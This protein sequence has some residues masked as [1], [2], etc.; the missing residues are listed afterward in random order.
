LGEHT[1]KPI[2]SRGSIGRLLVLGGALAAVLLF[3]L[4]KAG[5]SVQATS[6]QNPYVAPNVVDTNPKAHVV[7]TTLISKAASVDIGNGV[8]AH[9]QTFNGHIPGPTFHLNVGDTV[10]VHYKNRLNRPSGIHWHGVEVPNESDGTPFVQDLV[11]P[12]HSF[13][14]KFKVNRPGIFWYHPHHHDSTDQVFKGLYGMIVVT[15]PNEAKLDKLR[16]IPSAK[17]TIPMVLSD[18]TVCKTQGSNDTATYSPTAP[19]VGGGSLPPQMP[20]TPKNLCEGPGVT[21]PPPNPYP[22]DEDGSLR[23]PFSA[24]DIP[25][26]QTALHAGRVNEGQTVL[27]NGMNVGARAGTPSA[28]GAL[29][30]GASTLKVHPG[31]G[32]RMQILNASTVRYMRLRLTSPTGTQI[33]LVRIGGEGG[34]LNYAVTEGGLQGAY[35]TKYSPGEILLPPGSRAD[36]VAAIPASPTSGVATMW[37][38]DYQRSGMGYADTPTV[39]VAHFKIA[40]SPAPVPFHITGGSGSASLPPSGTALRARTGH[41]VQQLGPAT[42]TLLDPATFSPAKLGMSSPNIQ[43]TQ[44]AQTDLGV[45]GVFG[46]HD[47]SGSYMLAPHLGSSRY[48][49]PGSTLDLSVQNVTGA[50]HPF[51]LH[52]FSIQPIS[53][54]KAASPTYT[55]NYP[56]FRD[57]VDI[58][59]GYTLNF[60]VKLTP[61]PMMDGKTPGG[62]YGRW[63]LHCHIFFHAEDGMLSELV[64]V[65]SSGNE[66][67][68]V[69]VSHADVKVKAGKR[70]HLNGTFGDPDGNLVTLKSSVGKVKETGSGTYSWKYKTKKHEKSKIVYITAKDSTGLRGQ[71][72][73]QL[74]VKHR[75]H[76]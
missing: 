24:G 34:L 46:A 13:L 56:E 5:A 44:N 76:H 22:I 18:M 21:G 19:W 39:P 69:N 9:A 28:P 51:H 7:E 1:I 62:E 67:P 15:D 6:G 45:N 47:D 55:W 30:S 54:T 36:V 35:D 60:R 63:M 41:L 75:H 43:F 70:A 12:G 38:E 61:R 33:P 4:I 57:N 3:A 59:A 71:I 52:G 48:A 50:N 40:G 42:S 2:R 32:L 17:N 16:V 29:A 27:T 31:Q 11:K 58:P 8:T 49:T 74:R 26:I 20:P 14:Y 73:F 25:N 68:N 64:V 65:P 66:R 53:L 72:A 37:T 10:I 23:G